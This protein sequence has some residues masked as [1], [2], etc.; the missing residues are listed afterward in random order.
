M[1]SV[2]LLPRGMNNM[3]TF[4]NLQLTTI[5]CLSSPARFFLIILQQNLK[6]AY[7]VPSQKFLLNKQTNSFLWKV[8]YIQYRK[9][10]EGK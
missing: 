4:L 1:T 8:M 10:K 2:F 6:N 7:K 9:W 5:L 3:G